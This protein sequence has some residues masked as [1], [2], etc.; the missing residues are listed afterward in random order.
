MA[1]P[2]SERIK[3]I[4]IGC[5]H[6][7]PSFTCMSHVPSPRTSMLSLPPLML[8]FTSPALILKMAHAHLAVAPWSS[9]LYMQ[10]T[11]KCLLYNS[12]Q[13]LKGTASTVCLH[14][15]PPLT[16]L[17]CGLVSLDW[18]HHS[19]TAAH[20]QNLGLIPTLASLH[21]LHQLHHNPGRCG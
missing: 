3:T 14:Q 20:Y 15:T 17:V 16:G 9:D 21:P 2:F 18:Y 1:T 7:C 5:L 12:L 8:P 10:R 11:C 19:F 4:S 6:F 13:C